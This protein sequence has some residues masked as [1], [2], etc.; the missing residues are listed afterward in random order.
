MSEENAAND[1]LAVVAV[2]GTPEF[3][4]LAKNH[5]EANEIRAFLDGEATATN[6]YAGGNGV[7]LLTRVVDVQRACKIL[8]LSTRAPDA[9]SPE[10][11]AA[12]RQVMRG[13]RQLLWGASIGLVF[14]V[15]IG[16]ARDLDLAK[17]SEI[18]LTWTMAGAVCQGALTFLI[19]VLRSR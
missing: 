3:A 18:A 8:G 15:A 1:R 11:D 19:N 9:A 6:V 16:I 2:Y 7:R 14:G 4:H 12:R 13:L 5:L 10:V 17:G